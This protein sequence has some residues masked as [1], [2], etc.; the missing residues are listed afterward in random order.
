MERAARLRQIDGVGGKHDVNAKPQI[1]A[2]RRDFPED[3]VGFGIP[4]A[5][6]EVARPEFIGACGGRDHQ[7]EE[8]DDATN[9]MAHVYCGPFE[10]ASPAS[11]ANRGRSM[12]TV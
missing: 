8:T 3:V 11:R 12:V 6:F 9:E 10:P 7:C 5:Q 2:L 1:V 4:L